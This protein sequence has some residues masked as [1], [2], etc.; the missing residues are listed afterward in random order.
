VMLSVVQH[1]LCPDRVG[2]TLAGTC[3][4]V[5]YIAGAPKD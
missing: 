4:R 5:S 3:R 1:S 2:Q